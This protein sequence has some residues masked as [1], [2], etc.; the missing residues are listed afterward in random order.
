MNNQN[1]ISDCNRTKLVISQIMRSN[2]MDFKAYCSKALTNN[3]TCSIYNYFYI[4]MSY[5]RGH[6]ML[7][8]VSNHGIG[9]RIG[10]IGPFI[11]RFSSSYRQY[12]YRLVHI[13]DRVCNININ[14]GHKYM[15]IFQTLMLRLE[16]YIHHH[17]CSE[18]RR[19]SQRTW[20][21]MLILS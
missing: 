12:W 21:W 5:Y 4:L 15:A 7:N 6:S 9:M 14:I 20:L 8:M 17:R 19:N 3:F 11:G 1:K 13:L 18:L 10:N 2:G 16:T